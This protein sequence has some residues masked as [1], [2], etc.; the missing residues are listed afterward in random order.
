MKNTSTMKNVPH[1]LRPFLDWSE[2]STGLSKTSC[3]LAINKK[4][5]TPSKKRRASMSS[6]AIKAKAVDAILSGQVTGMSSVWENFDS[7]Q[8]IRAER[9]D[10][11]MFE[12]IIRLAV[13]DAMRSV[14]TIPHLFSNRRQ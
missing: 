8:K 7:L 14:A 12:E 3:V 4:T 13:R 9:G 2:A 5:R 1:D 6:V 11:A 10:S